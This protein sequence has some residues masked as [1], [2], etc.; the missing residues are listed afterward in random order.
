[1]SGDL[2]QLRICVEKPLP[3]EEHAIHSL[4]QKSNSIP[5]FNK[6]RAAFYTSKLW[7]KGSTIKI[8]FLPQASTTPL[9]SWTM[10]DVMKERRD[11]DGSPSP[12]D[13]IEYKIRGMSHQDAVKTVVEERIAPITDLKFDFV[14]HG[15]VCLIGFSANKGSWSQLGT[16]CIKASQKG[17]KTMNFGWMDAATIMHEFGHLLGM[18]H[19]H[20]NPDQNPIEWDL[21]KLY[22]WAK[23]T[24]DWDKT[25]V[26]HN[27]I[28]KYKMSQLNTSKFDPYSIML[29]FFPA[30]L[31]RNHK[32]T[33]INQRL[34]PVDVEYISKMYPGGRESP[35]AFYR[36]AYGETLGM[37]KEGF[38]SSLGRM[39]GMLIWLIPLIILIVIFVVYK[40]KGVKWIKNLRRKGRYDL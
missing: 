6:L 24:Q 11:A 33:N 23:K 34:S 36:K 39:P 38:L 28:G 22:A 9:A 3:D 2:A 32:A 29:Y 1:M 18:I 7:P 10:I 30:T 5:H 17:A 19:E 14:E 27:I 35:A 12:I 16:D 31:T 37:K 40:V 13:P 26:Q 21:P 4:M 20:D 15:G 8:Q 25:Q